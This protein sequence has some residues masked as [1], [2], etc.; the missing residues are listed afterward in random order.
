MKKWHG[1]ATLA[2]TTHTGPIHRT[3]VDRLTCGGGGGIAA[4]QLEPE[5]M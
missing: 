4:A 3:Y 5:Y 1:S 2:W